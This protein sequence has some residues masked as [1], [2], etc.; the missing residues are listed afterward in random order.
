MEGCT[1][2]QDRALF[3]LLEELRQQLAEPGTCAHSDN[4]VQQAEARV[5]RG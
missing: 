4:R 3:H 5:E 2:S 1:T